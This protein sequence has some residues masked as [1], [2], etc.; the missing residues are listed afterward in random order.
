MPRK[1]PTKKSEHRRQR[2]S[3]LRKQRRK[4]KSH[5]PAR[6]TSGYRMQKH[7]DYLSFLATIK[8]LKEKG[9]FSDQKKASG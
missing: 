4:N 7:V 8:E 6:M 1:K 2:K 3:L 5:N 9:Y